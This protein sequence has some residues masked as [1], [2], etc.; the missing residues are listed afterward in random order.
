[1]PLV[2][3]CLSLLDDQQQP[4]AVFYFFSCCFWWHRVCGCGMWMQLLAFSF[5]RRA[6]HQCHCHCLCT[7]QFIYCV[8]TSSFSFCLQSAIHRGIQRLRGN[9]NNA[10]LV[11]A[12]ASR[13]AN[14]YNKKRKSVSAFCLR[15]FSVQFVF[16]RKRW[17]SKIDT[18]NLDNISDWNECA[19]V[20]NECQ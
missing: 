14:A 3:F 2:S 8:C 9:T 4:A 7:N 15:P 11:N 19:R 20:Q 10:S 5:V 17:E 13:V 18:L 1:M 12:C 16:I 6:L